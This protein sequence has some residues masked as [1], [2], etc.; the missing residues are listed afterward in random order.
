MLLYYLVCRVGSVL[1]SNCYKDL[2]LK[3]KYVSIR[4]K[5]HEGRQRIFAVPSQTDMKGKKNKGYWYACS[6]ISHFAL[7]IITRVETALKQESEFIHCPVTLI[8]LLA[9]RK[10]AFTDINSL[11]E[12]FD[13]RPPRKDT[14]VTVPWKP[15]VLEERLCDISDQTLRNWNNDVLPRAGYKKNWKFY[16]IRYAMSNRL[17]GACVLLPPSLSDADRKSRRA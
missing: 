8:L 1:K 10:G 14:V 9:F 5:E 15:G 11:E 17:G 2:G 13:V 6:S 3:Y 4:V 12:L 16:S 7:L